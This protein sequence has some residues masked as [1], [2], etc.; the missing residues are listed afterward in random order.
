MTAFGEP[1]AA[2]EFGD[3]AREFVRRHRW[4]HRAK[5]PDPRRGRT[6]IIHRFSRFLRRLR[7]RSVVVE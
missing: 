1:D 6:L 4:R 7:R 2:A 5:L 3:F